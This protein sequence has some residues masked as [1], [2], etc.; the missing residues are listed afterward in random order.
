MYIV[1]VCLSV[2]VCVCVFICAY[3]FVMSACYMKSDW[4][5]DWVR[6]LRF[7]KKLTQNRDTPVLGCIYVYPKMSKLALQF[8]FVL[9]YFS[10]F[11]TIIY[12]FQ[13]LSRKLLYIL[14]DNID[15]D[16]FRAATTILEFRMVLA[17][18]SCFYL[19]KKI[20]YRCTFWSLLVCLIAEL[21]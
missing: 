4:T 18:K 6:F 5:I 3:L 16:F 1:Y 10:C 11:F 15:F 21:H 7:A 8:Y 13:D 2:I 19:L 20:W 9:L 14:L 12:N 17:V